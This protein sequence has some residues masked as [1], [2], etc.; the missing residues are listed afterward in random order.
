MM[1]REKL[2]LDTILCHKSRPVSD[3]YGQGAVVG[4]AGGDMAAWDG[5]GQGVAWRR[6]GLEGFA[7]GE[8]DAGGVA[9]EAVVDAGV[10]VVLEFEAD[11]DAVVGEPFGFDVFTFKFAGRGK[12]CGASYPGCDAKAAVDVLAIFKL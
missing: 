12:Q 5:Y 10:D 9:A 8:E 11:A 6:G 4:D 3:G 2:Q 7:D 1:D